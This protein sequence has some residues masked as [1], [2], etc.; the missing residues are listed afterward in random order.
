[1]IFFWEDI[2]LNRQ[3][4]SLFLLIFQSVGIRFFQGLGVTLLLLVIIGNY[5]NL[6]FLANARIMLFLGILILFCLVREI[7]FREIIL[8]VLM[9]VSTVCVVGE[10]F[11]LSNSFIQN[12]KGVASFFALYASITVV[13][14]FIIPQFFSPVSYGYKYVSFAGIFFTAN[15]PLILNFY[16]IS[17]LAWEPGCFQLITSLYLLIL[18]YENASIKKISWLVLLQLLSGSSTGYINLIIIGVFF[19]FKGKK[20]LGLIVLITIISGAIY[21]IVQSNLY[22]K[23]EGSGSGSSTIR[24][25]DFT[26]GVNKIIQNPIVGFQVSKLQ[27]DSDAKLIEDKVWEDSGNFSEIDS[28]GYFAGGYTNGLLG[29]FLNW[30]IPLGFWILYMFCKAPIIWTGSKLFAIFFIIIFLLSTLSEPIT[31]T[32]F[33]FLFVISFFY[34]SEFNTKKR[35][36]MMLRL[37]GKNFDLVSS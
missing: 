22:D 24:L 23:L 17:S 16:R 27:G 33:F 19:L 18:I 35:K 10:Y 8:Y 30:G 25:R 29:L 36:V 20:S 15:S 9:I 32:S 1:M 26:V 13:L 3:Q 31:A 37:K 7:E 2:K 12:F 5:K 11:L 6:K 21:P 14:L 28:L 34:Q 4:L